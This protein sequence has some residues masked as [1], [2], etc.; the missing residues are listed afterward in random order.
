MLPGMALLL[1]GSAS[2]LTITSAGGIASAEAFGSP[3]LNLH[4]VPTGIPTAEVFGT[5]RLNFTL[6]AGSISSAEAFGAMGVGEPP[7]PAYEGHIRR[8]DRMSSALLESFRRT[9]G[10]VYKKDANT[11]NAANKTLYPAIKKRLIDGTEPTDENAEWI[12]I[13]LIVNLSVAGTFVLTDGTN[14]VGMVHAIP[15]NV[16][17]PIPGPIKLGKGKPLAYTTTG[18]APNIQLEAWASELHHMPASPAGASGA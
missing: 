3:R 12:L 11:G 9:R 18:T 15:A 14:P 13:E 4:P 10:L 7:P 5:P 8:R 2:G 17:T 1:T 6:A 16:D